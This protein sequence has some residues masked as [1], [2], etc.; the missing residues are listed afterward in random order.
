M[1]GKETIL[2]SEVS[3]S[4]LPFVISD[5]LSLPA[6]EAESTAIPSAMPS[7]PPASNRYVAPA[8]FYAAP[9]RAKKPIESL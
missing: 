6:N 3:S 4:D 8:S 2:L 9:V 1:G 7:A 5:K